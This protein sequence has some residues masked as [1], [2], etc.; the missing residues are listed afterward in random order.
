MLNDARQRAIK[1]ADFVDQQRVVHL[2][3]AG[4]RTNAFAGGV[5]FHI[6]EVGKVDT[7]AEFTEK[8]AHLLLA[9]RVEG[10]RNEVWR[11]EHEANAV[12]W[13][14]RVHFPCQLQR[15]YDMAKERLKSD[16]AADGF[17]HRQY[18]LADRTMQLRDG[19]RSVVIRVTALELRR[20]ARAPGD[21][22]S[23]VEQIRMLG[24]Q[25]HRGDARPHEAGIV[26]AKEIE[27]G[28]ER[29]GFQLQ[30]LERIG[31][32]FEFVGSRL[33]EECELYHVEADGGNG[34]GVLA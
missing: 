27:I 20:E 1:L 22:L 13:K 33:E 4:A 6:F 19:F 31:E 34:L 11:V 32:R 25:F 29:G 26:G 14:R 30:L 12:G 10:G 7:V 9:L 5:E 24:D 8:A 3:A 2:A 16:T 21:K 28:A 15:A 17:E 23:A 18:D